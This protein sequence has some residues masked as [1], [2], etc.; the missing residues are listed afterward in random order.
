MEK[1]FHK[2]I[3]ESI[4]VQ[5]CSSIYTGMAKDLDVPGLLLTGRIIRRELGLLVTLYQSC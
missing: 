2:M 4:K 3:S 1:L 5:G